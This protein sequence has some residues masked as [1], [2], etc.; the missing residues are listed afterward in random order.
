MGLE[1]LFLF[2]RIIKLDLAHAFAHPVEKELGRSLA[3]PA[4]CRANLDVKGARRGKTECA[5]HV[6]DRPY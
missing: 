2:T 6:R 5:G 1:Y 4:R 3:D